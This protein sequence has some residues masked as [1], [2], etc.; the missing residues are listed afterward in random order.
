MFWL[1]RGPFRKALYTA[2][3]PFI[4]KIFLLL[5]ESYSLLL[6]TAIHVTGRMK[7]CVLG[8][9]PCIRFLTG[10]RSTVGIIGLTVRD[11]N[12]KDLLLNA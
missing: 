8:F 1:Y 12:V 7:L 10:E 3:A 5:A 9:L 2:L 4:S 6:S 11:I